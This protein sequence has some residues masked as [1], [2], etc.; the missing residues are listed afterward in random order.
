MHIRKA[1]T[2]DIPDI[3]RL[4]VDMLHEVAP[5]VPCGLSSRITEYL[6]LHISNGTCLCALLE[7]EGQVVAKAMLCTYETI[8]HELNLSGKAAVL[9]SVYTLPAYRGQGQC[10]TC[11]VIC[12]IG[13][14]TPA[15]RRSLEPLRKRRSLCISGWD[16]LCWTGK[17]TG[18]SDAGGSVK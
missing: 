1:T 11:W 8:P 14:G 4:R 6:H 3:T 5:F 18:G 15:Y 7:D 10:T 16:F 13:P 9:A 12:W 17:Y 2:A